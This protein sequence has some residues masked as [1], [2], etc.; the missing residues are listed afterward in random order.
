MNESLNNNSTSTFNK[1]EKLLNEENFANTENFI[2]KLKQKFLENNIFLN[3]K[4]SNLFFNYYL[5]LKER[6]EKINLTSITQ[7]DEV[8]EKHFLDSV[9]SLK[10]L[11]QN[12]RIIDLGSGA[13]FP[14]VPLKIL[15]EDVDVTLV[16]SVNK[17]VNFL[18][19]VISKLK[20]NKIIAVHTR[21]EDFA[22]NLKFR[23]KF[24]VVVSRAVSRLNTL[25]EYSLPFLKTGGVLIAYK[26]VEVESEIIEARRAIDLLGGKLEKV[27]NIPFEKMQRNLVFIKKI[28]ATPKKYPRSGN[29]PRINPII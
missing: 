10:F 18:N 2:S 19:E 11:P 17:K 7:E 1:K 15:R 28:E 6:N 25:C 9:V 13:G 27:E 16:D 8:I 14:G 22:N 24:D 23:E 5:L 29:K 21:I 12:A 26:S 20:L 4:Q 3:D